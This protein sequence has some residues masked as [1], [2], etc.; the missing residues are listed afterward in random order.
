MLI[1]CLLYAENLNENLV[2]YL[3]YAVTLAGLP[4][5]LL[6][7]LIGRNNQQSFALPINSKP[8]P[9]AICIFATCCDSPCKAISGYNHSPTWLARGTM[10]SAA[11][12]SPPGYILRIHCWRG[13]FHAYSF[14]YCISFPPRTIFH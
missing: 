6:P 9:S 5:F 12:G 13:F 11:G 7:Y 8:A 2:Y 4:G 14:Y 3:S 1:I 10:L